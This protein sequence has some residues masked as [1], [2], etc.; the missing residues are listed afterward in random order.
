MNF[1]N[2][3]QERRRIF[4][5]SFA[6]AFLATLT[7]TL[8]ALAQTE[9][10][11]YNFCSLPDCTDGYSANGRLIADSSG[12][13]YGTTLSGGEGI[14]TLYKLSPDGAETVLYNFGVM[15]GDGWQPQG[16]VTMD[17][18]GNFYG[19]TVAGG[20]HGLGTVFK[21]SPDGTETILHSFGATRYDGTYPYGP[22]VL[23]KNGNVYGSTNLGG[24]YA[25]ACGFGGEGCGTV[26][27]IGTDGK[28]SIIHSF[29]ANTEG[30]FPYGIAID[31]RGNLYGTTSTGGS[32]NDG[33]V[34][35]LTNK[36]VY[37]ILSNFGTG[38][39]D[40][41]SPEGNLTVDAKGN[42]YGAT[43]LGG[44]FYDGVVF[45]LT[46]GSSWTETT[47]Y[48]FGTNKDDGSEPWGG[49]VL[50]G[51]GNLY[52]TT[53]EGGLYND[54]TVFKISPAGTETL[55]YT[56]TGSSDGGTPSGPLLRDSSGKLY[57]PTYSGGS[58]SEGVIYKI[59]P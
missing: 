46:P 5:A 19:V 51:Q 24:E 37:S 53:Y 38:A 40:G 43:N 21:I 32:A 29:N 16:G 59:T 56:F 50:D 1:T 9:S 42:V 41:I 49:L 14:G 48:S 52:G 13:L 58:N 4:V 30:Y 27:R 45:K 55:L 3:S 44:A 12:N 7:A 23:D 18:E 36:G 39:S 17:K 35:E 28:E 34:Y 47:L 6:V 8:P 15:T 54:G 22:V 10:V 57:G 20:A 31:E 2:S 11:V 26:F 25:D 33:T